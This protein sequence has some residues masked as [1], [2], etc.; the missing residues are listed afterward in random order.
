MALLDDFASNAVVSSLFDRISTCWIVH[1]FFCRGQALELSD[2]YRLPYYLFN[3]LVSMPS[4]A[5]ISFL[6]RSSCWCSCCFSTVSMPSRTYISFLRQ[7]EVYIFV[8]YC[9][10]QCPLGLISHFYIILRELLQTA[11]TTCQCP[12]G[13]ISHFYVTPSKT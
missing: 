8:N 4:R 12:L 1:P 7:K 11:I 9:G 13:L 5:Y 6:L 10:C 3:K 2:C